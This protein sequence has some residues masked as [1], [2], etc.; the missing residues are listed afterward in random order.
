MMDLHPRDHYPAAKINVNMNYLLKTEP[1]AYS[2]SDLERD[3]TTVWDGVNNPVALNNLRRMAPKD[4]LI[5][6]HTGDERQTIGIASVVDADNSDPLIQE[7]P[8]KLARS[9]RPKPWL[10]SK[11]TNCLKLRLCCAR[12]DCLW[13]R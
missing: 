11:P 10:R 5:I 9:C 4:Q 6:Y 2:F 7:S 13:F 1:S 12:E 8:S 3:G